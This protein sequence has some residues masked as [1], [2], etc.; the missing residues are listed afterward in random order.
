MAAPGAGAGVNHTLLTALDF[1]YGGA[2]VVVDAAPGDAADRLERPCVD[3]GS[4]LALAGTGWD[5]PS[6]SNPGWC[7]AAGDLLGWID[8]LLYP[9]ALDIVVD[10]AIAAAVALGSDSGK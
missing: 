3:A 5:S 4:I 10:G 2:H 9:P 6:A 1:S 8:C 7:T